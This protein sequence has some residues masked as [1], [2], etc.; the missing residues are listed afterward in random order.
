[1]TF[2]KLFSALLIGLSAFAA[3]ACDPTTLDEWE[4][5]GSLHSGRARTSRWLVLKCAFNDDR[6]ARYFPTGLNAAITDLDDYVEK[7]LTLEGTGTGNLIDY[8]YDV[9][10]GKILLTTKVMGWYTAP[11]NTGT[12]NRK[13]IVQDCANAMSDED[14]ATIDFADYDGIIVVMNKLTNG[15]ACKTGKE[16]FSIKGGT[17][18]LGCL[19]FDGDSMYASFAA[20]EV[21][22]GLG[23]PHSADTSLV[24]YTDDFDLMSA[25]RV[26][27]FTWPN[28]P[29]RGAL[30]DLGSG[31]GMSVPNLLTLDAIPADR[32]ATFSVGSPQQKI[33]LT[34]LSRPLSAHPLAVKIV[35][36]NLPNPLTIEYRQSEGWDAGIPQ[37]LVLVHQYVAGG[38][39]LSIL[40][41]GPTRVGDTGGWTQGQLWI[42]TEFGISM[43]VDKIDPATGTAVISVD[44]L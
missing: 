37:N 20:H 27:M 30:T 44:T 10:Y 19:T 5:Y 18:Q 23:L 1:M 43:H 21:G 3:A 6:D 41:I 17:Y 7:Y 38:R 29:G 2:Q 15:G 35:G 8:F 42:G 9:T 34:A 26:W 16:T 28:Y 36:P 33:T 39:P 4:G 11:F 31:P 24:D 25:L 40:Q 12:T 32:I 14:A 13:Q 22:H